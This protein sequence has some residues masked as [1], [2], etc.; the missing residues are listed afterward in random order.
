MHFYCSKFSKYKSYKV[1]ILP[2]AT[3]LKFQLS[4]FLP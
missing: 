2:L 3:Y 1:E 4:G